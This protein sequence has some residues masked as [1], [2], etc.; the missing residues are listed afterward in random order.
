MHVLSR[1]SVQELVSLRER[2]I[3]VDEKSIL[4]PY[5]MSEVSRELTMLMFSAASSARRQLGNVDC[6]A[7]RISGTYFI[8]YV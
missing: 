2:I 6:S 1:L 4:A 8:L 3:N 5:N 7:E